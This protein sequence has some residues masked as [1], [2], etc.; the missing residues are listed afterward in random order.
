M[1]EK[2]KSKKVGDNIPRKKLKLKEKVHKHIK[3]IHDVITDEDI[4]NAAPDPAEIKKEIK[5]KEEELKENTK[6]EEG[7]KKEKKKKITPWDIL[8]K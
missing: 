6:I 4:R 7:V 3:D 2:S 1:P 5:Q 8:D